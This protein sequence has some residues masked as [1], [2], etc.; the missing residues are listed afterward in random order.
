M[1]K[2]ELV[3]H[4]EGHHCHNHEIPG[5]SCITYIYIKEWTEAWHHNFPNLGRSTSPT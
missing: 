5:S 1:K 4:F 2:Q 3:T